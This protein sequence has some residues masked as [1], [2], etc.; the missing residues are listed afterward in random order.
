LPEFLNL[1]YERGAIANARF[2]QDGRSVIYDAT[3]DG[4]PVRVFTTPSDSA[5]P[6]ALDFDKAHLYAV[7]P[8]GELAIGTQGV[9][10]NHLDYRNATL[11][12][13]PA[14]GG[15]ARAVLDN[16]A[17]ADWAPDGTL[18]VVH[19]VNG[20]DRIE[21]P[22]GKVLFETPGWINGLRISPKGDQIAFLEHPRWPDDRGSVS[23]V[24]TSGNKRTVSEEF[25]SLMGLA[26][27]P[28]GE[29]WFTGT[30]G[31]EYRALQ[32]VDLTGHRRT[33]LRVPGVLTIFDIAANGRVLMSVSS[34]KVGVKGRE[35]GKSA[36][37]DLSWSGWSIAADIT[38]DGKSLL[39]NEQSHIAGPDYV[40]AMRTL[41]GSAPVRLGIG[42]IGNLSPDGKWV[43]S[44]PLTGAQRTLIYPVGVGTTKE[45]PVN[46]DKLHYSS[47][48]DNHHLLVQGYEPGHAVRCLNQEIETGKMTPVTPEGISA[49]T[50]SLDGKTFAA[51][52]VGGKL[53]LYSVDG[54]ASRTIPGDTTGMVPIRFGTD[55]SLYASYPNEVP[56]RVFKIDVVTGRQ[57]VVTTLAPGDAAG[58]IGI[59]PVAL[60]PDGKSYAYSYRRTLSELYVVDGLK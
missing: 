41:D 56:Q 49:C 46:L 37:Q 47:F 2:T 16:V 13:A 57:Q 50:G 24:N 39:F 30:S 51:P 27:T 58:L 18:A 6:R 14:A 21:F 11:D 28:N 34:E 19:T 4:K 7:S 60:S 40:V 54:G 31:T 9:L 59:S 38:S 45:L 23:V 55:G 25:E 17:D 8:T 33:I 5:Q 1:S 35:S 48:T 3:W 22:I 12:R 44:V 20:H 52:D 43:T 29:I 32:A 42:N 36:E 26:W 15:A 10:G 53:T